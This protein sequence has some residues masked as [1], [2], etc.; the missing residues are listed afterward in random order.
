MALFTPEELEEL[1]LYDSRLDET[2][3]ETSAEIVASYDRDK[4]VKWDRLDNKQKQEIERKRAR[5]AAN[6]QKHRECKRA[7]NAANREKA[8]EYARAYYAVNREK[9]N[10]QMREYRRKKQQAAKLVNSMHISMNS[11]STAMPE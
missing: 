7:Y 1:R 8:R 3:V 4:Q 10:A 9:R 2:F 5:Y 6:R 11:D